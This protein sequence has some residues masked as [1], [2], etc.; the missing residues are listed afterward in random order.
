MQAH[1]LD[2]THQ[3]CAQGISG[4]GSPHIR[5]KLQLLTSTMLQGGCS[6]KLS[7]PFLR[8]P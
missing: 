8:S 1:D 2:V 3:M 5:R 4:K 7:T 6:E